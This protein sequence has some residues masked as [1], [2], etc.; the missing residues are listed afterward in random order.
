[1][2]MKQKLIYFTCA[3][4][5]LLAI[6]SCQREKDWQGPLEEKVPLFLF[7]DIEQQVVT[8]A[9]DS[10]FADGDHVGIWAV[11]YDGDDPG[12]LTLHGN[13]AN[14]VRY[15]LNGATW[16]PDY[17]VYYKD[18]NTPV[19]L[20]GY[21]PYSS[22]ISS[23]DAYPFE[24]QEDQSTM[25]ANGN[26]SGY[27]ASDFLWAKREAVEPTANAVQLLFKHK[28][29]C[30]VVTLE[31]GT[32]FSD[33]E[34]STLSQSVLINNVKRNATI[35]LSTGVISATGAIASRG[36]VP[37]PYENGFRAIVVPQ[38][39]SSG[40]DLFTITLGG[41]PYTYAEGTA[42]TYIAGKQHI[43]TITVNKKADGGYDV[44]V[45]TSISAWTNDNS[46]HEFTAREYVVV[47]VETPG[48]LG[49]V[50]S[51]TG[52]NPNAIKFLKITGTIN[53]SD[54]S[55]MKNSMTDLR[56]V[57]MK[58][59]AVVGNEIP[60]AAFEGK[61]LLTSFVFPDGN[62]ENPI[63]VVRDMAFYGTSLSGALI[64]PEGLQTI[65]NSA[66]YKTPINSIS[67][68]SSLLSI[69]NGAFSY[70]SGLIGP[71][72]FPDGLLNIGPGAFSDC[73]SLNGPL[74]LP[75]ELETI[76]NAAFYNCAAL[77]GS[78]QI[79]DKV[80]TIGGSAFE[81]CGFNGRLILPDGLEE[82]G[83]WT[84]SQCHFKGELVLPQGL[85][86]IGQEA[87]SYNS[88]TGNLV[89]PQDL[90]S[91]G[92]NAFSFC[93]IQGVLVIP[94]EMYALPPGAF[95]ENP[96]LEG[97]VF[98]KNL[99]SIGM[100]CFE[101]CYGIY[102]IVSHAE[103]PPVVGTGAFD[104][105]AKDNFTVEVPESSV[106]DYIYAN[107]WMDFNRIAA[108][109]DFSISRRLYRTLNAEESKMIIVRAESNATWQVESK[110]DWVSVSP[111]SGT[112][113]TDVTITVNALGTGS[114]NRNG[115]VVFLLDGK[116]Y[117]STLM[118]EQYDYMHA[119][120]QVLTEQTHSVGN[121]I[122]IVFM[123]DCYD[124]SNIASGDY[125]TDT[126]AAIHHFFDI[127][128]YSIYRNYFDIYIVFGKSEDSGVGSINTIREAKFGTQYSVTGG[129]LENNSSEAFVYSRKIDENLDMTKALIVMVLNSTEYGGVTYMWGDGSA[130]A[131]C[132][133][134]TEA[135]PYDF[136]GLVQHEAGGHG[137]GKLADEYIYFNAFVNA[138]SCPYPHLN[139]FLSA[140]A[141][142]W[143]E[144]LSETSNREDVPWSHLMYHENYANTV[145]I[146]EGGFFHTRGIFRSEPNSCM[147]NNIP[148]Y[149]AI[150]REAIVR[151]IM[152]Y[153]GVPFSQ[154][155]FYNNDLANPT[156]SVREMTPWG[157]DWLNNEFNTKHNH[158]VFMGEHP[159]LN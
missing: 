92:Q 154:E 42:F 107:G 91:L 89:L 63:T 34:F 9:S 115:D 47:N 129:T 62:H 56:G 142:G 81:Y 17:D 24:V 148:Y 104:G 49:T 54:F 21:Y 111:S 30:V 15:T 77:T 55:F 18:K 16:T 61:T 48:T 74:A 38:T 2:I 136:R 152:D 130:I 139:E 145:D 33:G 87:F 146:Y 155:D 149:S 132:P 137:F 31:E 141:R 144:N 124:A 73:T 68:P 3:I 140:K 39:I 101:N 35:N 72:Q 6:A 22:A 10:G 12:T 67:F 128:P 97:V 46:S 51:A 85:V 20:F 69:E 27:E 64:L 96:Q 26:L 95:K 108:H 32:G 37:V 40:I 147:N 133:K 126:R 112:G 1:M 44:T 110:P 78:L 120:G 4:A 13:Q 123:G 36:T 57:N 134:S 11:N 28:M 150:S 135:Y 50:L 143:Y 7:G 153:A 118:V 41:I 113:K 121:G 106:S 71:L 102:S 127:E 159:T 131:I 88:F 58:E 75:K 66:F 83:N 98:S 86:V 5:G 103:Q 117:R 116:N 43:F 29:S 90:T 82:I 114:G 79:P 14:N 45:E 151:R 100:Y 25:A 94:D 60:Y 122:P 59:A 80:T 105:V 84:F 23:V 119:D 158:P 156:R 157:M 99:T 93:N 76:G 125:L 19:D 52:K 109:R 8:R 70:C 53:D 138:C 65:R